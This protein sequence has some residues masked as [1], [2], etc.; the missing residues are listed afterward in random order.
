MTIY[1]NNT[2]TIRDRKIIVACL[3]DYRD[4][5]VESAGD[6]NIMGLT[7]EEDLSIEM[8]RNTKLW[9]TVDKIIARVNANLMFEEDFQVIYSCFNDALDQF[10]ISNGECGFIQSEDDR[11]TVTDIYYKLQHNSVKYVL[12]RDVG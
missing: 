9:M 5:Y 12:Q 10:D 2:L 3:S 1:T 11:V 8:S 6:V 4:L 7:F